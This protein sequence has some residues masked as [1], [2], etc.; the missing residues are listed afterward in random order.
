MIWRIAENTRTCGK[1]GR[2]IA[3]GERYATFRERALSYRE[4]ANAG[5]LYPM[6]KRCAECA[7]ERGALALAVGREGRLIQ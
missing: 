3:T 5:T 7:S 1:C 2:D 6:R 4:A